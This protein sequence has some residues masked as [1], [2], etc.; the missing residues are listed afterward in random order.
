MIISE[1]YHFLRSD[2]DKDGFN[3][4][5]GELFSEFI[6]DCEKN[7]HKKHGIY[8]AN[9]LFANNLTMLLFKRCNCDTEN[10]D[11]GMELIEGNIDLDT[12]LAIETH[13]ERSTIYAIGSQADDDEPLWLIVD[14]NVKDETFELK[15]IPEDED[16]EAIEKNLPVEP[17]LFKFYFR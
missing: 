6:T 8:Y 7:F 3:I 13:S 12:N 11:Y 5:N 2:F 9:H 16:D 4:H 17:E 10:E 1:T 15:Y 14:D